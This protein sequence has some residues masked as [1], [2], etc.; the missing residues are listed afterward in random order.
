MESQGLCWLSQKEI[1]DQDQEHHV[2]LHLFSSWS[3]PQMQQHMDAVVPGLDSNIYPHQAWEACFSIQFKSITTGTLTKWQKVSTP[4][5]MNFI[6]CLHGLQRFSTLVCLNLHLE[7]TSSIHWVC[8]NTNVITHQYIT[9]PTKLMNMVLQKKKW[10]KGKKKLPTQAKVFHRWNSHKKT[11]TTKLGAWKGDGP[12][13]GQDEWAC[14]FFGE[15]IMCKNNL[16][17]LWQSERRIFLQ[18][19]C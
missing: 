18:V 4:H 6:F 17:Q 13:E 5:F 9:H 15:S 1:F 19:L 12:Y 3:R 14:S 10:N 7:C 11:K 2:H 8:K 16:K